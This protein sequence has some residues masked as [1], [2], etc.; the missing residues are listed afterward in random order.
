MTLGRT[1]WVDRNLKDAWDRIAA[2]VPESWM[3][4]R[5]PGKKFSVEEYGCGHYG[6]VMPTAETTEE[7]NIVFKLTSDVTEARFVVMSMELPPTEGI[8]KYYKIFALKDTTHRRRPVFVLWREGA[9]DIGILTHSFLYRLRREYASEHITDYGYDEYHIHSIQEGRKHLENFLTWARDAREKITTRLLRKEGEAREKTLAA[10]WNA[11]ESAPA[12][13]DPRH[14]KGLPRIGIALRMCWDSAMMIQNTD[15]V[16]PIGAALGHYLDEG[17]LLADVH[18]NNIG[19][20]K[21]DNLII[22]DPGH[23][24]ECHPRWTQLPKV[25]VI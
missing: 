25:P 14:Y 13:A 19:R 16:Y 4:E 3:P 23:A 8:V 15:V 12:D 9:K 20:D 10:I 7:E 17:I 1:P 22:T 11:F 5:L 24:V 21:D 18:L 6:C 2:Q